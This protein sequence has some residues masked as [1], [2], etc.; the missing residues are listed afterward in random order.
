MLSKTPAGQRPRGFFFG[1]VVRLFGF[2]FV[3]AAGLW[4]TACATAAPA[5]PRRPLIMIS[6][7]HVAGALT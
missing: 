4:L 1:V 7:G 5:P 6:M 2:C 3:V